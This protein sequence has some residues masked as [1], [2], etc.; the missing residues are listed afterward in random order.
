M[1]RASSPGER[2]NGTSYAVAQFY[3]P[4]HGSSSAQEPGPDQC[5]TDAGKNGISETMNLKDFS[6]GS[7]YC[8]VT[9]DETVA[10]L[11]VTATAGSDQTGRVLQAI[12]WTQN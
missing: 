8:F 6:V 7:A 12:A 1:S 9:S 2:R 10:W 4:E 11:K 3:G 5:Q